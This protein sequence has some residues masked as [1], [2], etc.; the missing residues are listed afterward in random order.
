[1]TSRRLAPLL[2]SLALTAAACAG[3]VGEPAGATSLPTDSVTYFGDMNVVDASGATSPTDDVAVAPDSTPAADIGSP[4]A[5]PGASGCPCDG[6]DDCDNALCIDSPG[7]KTCAHKCVD[8]CPDGLKCAQVTGDG[9][10]VVSIC[11]AKDPHLC[12]PCTAS[13][14]CASLGA[15]DGLCVDHGLPGSF[16]GV[17]CADAAGCPPDYD[18]VEVAAV[19]GTKAKQCVPAETESGA[20]ACTCS[21]A[22]A[23][24]KLETACWIEH[25]NE[26]GVLT[27][28]AGVARCE[29]EGPAT[30][31]A[32]ELAPEVCDGK[33]NDCDG[34]VDQGTCDDDNPCT[35]DSCGGAAGCSHLTLSDGLGCDADGNVCTDGDTCKG[36]VCAPGALK[37][38]D[39][40]NPCTKDVCDM[41]TGCTQLHD[42]GAPCD[43]DNPCTVGDVCQGGQCDAGILKT[44]P[45]GKACV[46][47]ECSLQTGKCVF[48]DQQEGKVCDDGD[49]CTEK[50]ACKTGKCLGAIA[51]CDDGNPCTSDACDPATGCKSQAAPGACSD[52]NPCTLGDACEAGSCKSGTVKDCNDSNG[53]TQD[54]CNLASGDCDHLGAKL[55]G[56]PCDADGSVCTQADACKGGQC[57]KGAALNCDD[58]N[59]CTADTCDSI[60]G[61]EHAVV[62]GSCDA[63]GSACT[64][65]DSCVA[66]KCI[67]GAPMSCDDGNPCTVDGCV[68][69]S[70]SCTH[71]PAKLEG[72]SCDADG[73]ACTVGDI[74]TDGACKAGKPT[75]CADGNACT[76][77]GCDAK[78]GQCTFDSQALQDKACNGDDDGCTVGDVCKGGSCVVGAKA[79]C[80]KPAEQCQIAA[81]VSKGAASFACAN[82]AKADVSPCSDGDACTVVDFC[83]GGKCQAGASKSC[84]GKGFCLVGACDGQS[85]LCGTKPGNE[86]KGCSDGSACTSNDLCKGGTCTG[87]AVTCDDGK[88]CTDDLCDKAGGCLYVANS[89]FCD[90]GDACTVSDVCGNKTCKGKPKVC[91][92]G[93]VCTEDFCIKG[94]GCAFPPNSALCPDADPCTTA[95][96]CVSGKCQQKALSCD[97]GN[98][99]TIDSCKSGAGCVHGAV[100]NNTG[101]GG[102]NWCQSGKCVP[103]NVPC[104]VTWN[105]SAKGTAIVLSNGN[106]TIKSTA[107][108]NAARATLGRSTGKWYYEMIVSVGGNG[109][110]FIGAGTSAATLNGCCTGNTASWG[111]YGGPGNLR[112]LGKNASPN[113]TPYKSGTFTIGVA[114]DLSLDR[115]WWSRQGVW[116]LGGNPA[117]GYKPTF[118][119]VAGTIY[120]QASVALSNATATLRACASEL[121]YAPPAGFTAWGG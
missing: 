42:N 7:G 50:D 73:S 104:T 6:N 20:G 22:A 102:N 56:T 114:V 37:N 1:M 2:A 90:D 46:I 27:K 108:W 95:E 69:K 40:G 98:A 96:I 47:G 75:M 74:C 14:D 113:A 36:G 100:A 82:V 97:D 89:A 8:S 81:C 88:I 112:G 17:A 72:Q 77:D 101:C 51:S 68:A 80:P 16:C 70:G 115:I 9:G 43:D 49:A 15:S 54:S 66:G 79:T 78:S 19:E 35:T 31:A 57:S 110:S 21:A 29:S 11:V 39:D 61:C 58:G 93:N 83:N 120:P 12:D 105:P 30:C 111:Y 67:A 48:A 25:T 44:C 28:C 87:T 117:T 60:K 3:E 55:E 84:P 106:K 64:K 59:P 33:D 91:S 65:N 119:N 41:A 71:D 13:S 45:S 85:G 32:P 86:G 121:K 24:A 53:C 4:N 34:E 109:F 99:C 94:S 63:D 116:Q 62:S 18:C 23:A 76:L 5:C 107:S 118:S 26:A 52:A 92:D 103:K 38:C 10:D